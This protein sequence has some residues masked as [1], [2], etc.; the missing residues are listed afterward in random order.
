MSLFS[1]SSLAAAAA[2]VAS[3]TVTA[4][5]GATVKHEGTWPDADKA[6]TLDVTALP[7]TEALRRLADAAG[8]SLVVHAPPGDPVEIHVKN[9]PPPRCSTC[10]STTATTS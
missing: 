7:R 2:L 8:W 10:C 4:V 3:V 5:A 1:G 9:T 6:V